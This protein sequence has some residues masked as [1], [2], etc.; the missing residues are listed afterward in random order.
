MP[1]CLWG[2]HWLCLLSHSINTSHKKIPQTL[3]ARHPQVLQRWGGVE[4]GI[5]APL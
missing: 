3:C 1:L 2:V 5:L 4:W